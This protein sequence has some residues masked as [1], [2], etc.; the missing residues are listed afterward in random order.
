MLCNNV[1]NLCRVLQ[2]TTAKATKVRKKTREKNG[3]K[4]VKT[5]GGNVK[6]QK[7]CASQ[8]NAV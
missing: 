3:K 6:K 5:R 8:H 1:D 7:A 2:Q 4:R